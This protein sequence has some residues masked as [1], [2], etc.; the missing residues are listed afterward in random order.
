MAS[1]SVVRRKALMV[2]ADDPPAGSTSCK[3]WPYGPGLA[4]ATVA[5]TQLRFGMPAAT[6]VATAAR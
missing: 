1:R 6:A 4:A 2:G 3:A 5:S